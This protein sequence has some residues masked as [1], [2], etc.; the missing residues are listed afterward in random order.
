MKEKRVHESG[1]FI[2]GGFSGA[3]RILH[4][5]SACIFGLVS[6]FLVTRIL[7]MEGCDFIRVQGH[8]EAGSGL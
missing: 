4:M 3:F 8:K 5:S 6:I 1:L 7:Q 2:V